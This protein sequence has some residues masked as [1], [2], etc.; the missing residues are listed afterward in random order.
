MRGSQ[1]PELS[2]QRGISGVEGAVEALARRGLV[3]APDQADE[4]AAARDRLAPVR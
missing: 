2:D 1:L 4:C 3:R